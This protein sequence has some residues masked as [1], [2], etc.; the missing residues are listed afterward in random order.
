TFASNSGVAADVRRRISAES[1]AL[2]PPPHVG[3]YFF[4]SLLAVC[5]LAMVLVAN[6]RADG[7]FALLSVATNSY[8]VVPHN[9][10]L[11]AFPLTVT[12]WFK[13]SQI[14]NNFALVSK[15]DSVSQNGWQLYVT[16]GSLRAAY[17]A[18]SF[19]HVG[20]DGGLVNT[21]GWHH[22][23]FVVNG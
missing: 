2:F 3:G 14:S 4:R 9:A 8:A 1:S 16:N 11:N 6:A 18:D 5:S 7:P 19:T 10:A 13:I 21:S 23:A 15:Y 20:L 22:V 17:F 12:C